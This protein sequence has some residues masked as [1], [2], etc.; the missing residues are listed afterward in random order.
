MSQ[1]KLAPRLFSE[2]GSR[3]AIV[4]TGGS[5]GIGAAIVLELARRGLVVGCLSRRGIGPEDVA[6]D[7]A[8]AARLINAACDVTDEGQ[9]KRALEHIVKRAGGLWG[10]VNN[11]AVSI[12]APADRV[13]KS[14]FEKILQTNVIGSFIVCREAYSY[15]V[16]GGGGIIVNIGSFYDRIGVKR[17]M[18]YCASKAALG[19]LTRCLAV[20]WGSKGITVVDIAPGYVE[21]DI[22]RD[23][24]RREEIKE[25]VAK[26]V[27]IARTGTVSEVARLVASVFSEDLRLLNGH[28]IY[29]DGGQAIAH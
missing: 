22:N 5:R 16:G 3:G 28:T 13:A 23:F 18:A 10:V 19:A 17:H 14:D 24:L 7:V 1:A 21:T 20:E 11:A 4:V 2:S 29:A 26:R 9:V 25:F 27:P 12:A 8:L 6:V 15:L